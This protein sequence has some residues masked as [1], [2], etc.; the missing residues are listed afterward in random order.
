ME[1]VKRYY[2]GSRQDDSVSTSKPFSRLARYLVV[3]HS[4]LRTY[5]GVDG[6]RARML[7]RRVEADERRSYH[8]KNIPRR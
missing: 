6:I 3:H 1:G 8:T 4:S 2:G 5:V 7:P